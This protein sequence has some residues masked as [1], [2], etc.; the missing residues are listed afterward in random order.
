MRLGKALFSC[1]M[2][3]SEHLL[4][5]Q[6]N[7][8]ETLQQLQSKGYDAVGCAANVS[9]LEDV[10]ALINLA[11]STYGRIDVLVSN[12]AVNPAAGEILDIPDW[13]IDKLLAVNVK[14]SIQLIRE[15]RPHLSKVALIKTLTGT[16]VKYGLHLSDGVPHI[17]AHIL[18]ATAGQ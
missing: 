12:A 1:C 4:S 11:V 18:A 8:N 17:L 16:P 15:A 5:I 2:T 14:A 10:K 6:D 9:K 3:D 7:V 13:A